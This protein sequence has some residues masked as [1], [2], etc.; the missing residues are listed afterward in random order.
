[1]ELIKDI[2]TNTTC[3]GSTYSDD[4][5]CSGKII[6][7]D[8]E[9]F[10]GLIVNQ[11][12]ES[13][14][15][16]GILSLYEMQMHINEDS[17]LKLYRLYKE[18]LDRNKY[19]GDYFIELPNYEQPLGECMVRVLEPTIYRDVNLKGEIAGLQEMM[20]K[21]KIKQSKSRITD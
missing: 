10:E 17:V 21:C 20:A 9:S 8:D 1:M 16:T 11:D 14:I 6:L 12:N 5:R 3:Y 15:V 13:F 7:K 2:V 19:Y 18:D 4:N